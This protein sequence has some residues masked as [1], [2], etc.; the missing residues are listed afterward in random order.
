[1]TSMGLLPQRLAQCFPSGNELRKG[2]SFYRVLARNGTED[3]YLLVQY[4]QIVLNRAVWHLPL[5]HLLLKDR[6]DVAGFDN[7]VCD[8]VCFHDEEH[9]SGRCG[10]DKSGREQ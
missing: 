9:R 8:L 5:A 2:V 6:E 1:M 4:A 3:G 7:P 10:G